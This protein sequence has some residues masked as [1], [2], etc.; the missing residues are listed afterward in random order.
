MTDYSS[1]LSIPIEGNSTTQFFSKSGGL[2]AT[3]YIRIVIGGRDPYVEFERGQLCYGQMHTPA[4]QAWR[5]NAD[6]VY[7]YEERITSDNIKVYH[8]VGRVDYA[9][10]IPGLFYISLFDLYVNDKVVIE[11]LKR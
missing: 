11:K 7:Y 10:Y 9:D 6:F 8:Q 4:D 5:H 2:V 1:R 3:G